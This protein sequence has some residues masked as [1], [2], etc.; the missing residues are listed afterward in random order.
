MKTSV[1][2]RFVAVAALTVLTGF[3]FAQSLT[4]WQF[5]DVFTHRDIGFFCQSSP[6]I[7]GQARL[8]CESPNGLAMIE[9]IGPPSNLTEASL[10]TFTPDANDSDGKA[11]RGIYLLGFIKAVYPNWNGMVDWFERSFQRAYDTGRPVSTLRGRYELEVSV[12]PSLGM[13]VVSII[14]R[15]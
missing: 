1:V 6:L 7:G 9:L 15:R 13:V 2:G 5:V 4:R 3:A 8:L 12:R 11:L 14:P 10:L